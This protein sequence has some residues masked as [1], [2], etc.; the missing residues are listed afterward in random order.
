MTF[1]HF[2][3]YFACILLP[4]NIL[5]W[6]F[7]YFRYQERLERTSIEEDISI[8][9]DVSSVGIIDELRE[10]DTASSTC[11]VEQNTPLSHDIACYMKSKT[12]PKRL[13]DATKLQLLQDH[14]HPHSSYSFPKT[15]MNGC[16]RS[17]RHQ[18]LSQ[19]SW[20]VYS[21]S[22]D[23][24]YCLPCVLFAVPGKL[25][26]LVNTP[27]KRWTK[28]SDVVGQHSLKK[29]H[30]D[31]L[32]AAENFKRTMTSNTPI[33]QQIDSQRLERI[34]TNKAV[35]QSI[36][37]TIHFLGKQ[38]LPLRGHRDDSTADP[39][40]NKGNFIELLS[41]RGGVGDSVLAHH[42][43]TCKKNARY[44]SKTIQNEL[45]Q[46]IGKQIKKTIVNKIKEAKFFSVLCDEVTD[47]ANIEQVTI[48]FRFVDSSLQIREEFIEFK[49]TERI[50]GECLARLI[51]DS[52]KSLGLDV[53][54]LRGQGYDGASNMSSSV[55][56][57]QGIIC[58]ESPLAF[59]VHC[60]CHILN[61]VIVKA[62]S[63]QSVRNMAG[64]NTETAIFFNFSA[65]RQ[66]FLESVISLDASSQQRKVK[67]KDLCRTRWIQRHEAYETF[68]E[69]LPS[70][71]KVLET[72]VY[73]SG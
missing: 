24:G 36:A 23:G 71:V 41:F 31:T 45:I 10:I 39:A 34:N 33:D 14:F 22:Q 42:L 32:V 65:K 9:E 30:H 11:A 72:I 13:P 2:Y 70:V 8:F 40:A 43:D 12:D 51:L 35:L 15:D 55:K 57:V 47:A 60:N 1:L 56:G 4:W 28:L 37:E 17:F 68:F 49:S 19:F 7:L 58:R 44:S 73:G 18:W 20:L 46:I 59:Y 64:T 63:I 5:I 3:F 27:F 62:C 26:Q 52:I 61:L 6:R 69:L 67:L 66:R 29:Y 50:T 54:L 53:S 16:R 38:G 48:V 25:G 21:E